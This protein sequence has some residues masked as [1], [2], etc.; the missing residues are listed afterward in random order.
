MSPQEVIRDVKT[1]RLRGRGGAGFPTG[2]KWDFTRRRPG[3]A[4]S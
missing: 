4:S 3:E 1:S 2:M